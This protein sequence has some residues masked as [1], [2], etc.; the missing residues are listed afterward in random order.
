MPAWLTELH[1]RHN[2]VLKGGGGR[3][4]HDRPKS[5]IE[6]T[7]LFCIQTEN[8]FWSLQ[9]NGSNEAATSPPHRC[10]CHL[11]AAPGLFITERRA[12]Q[13]LADSSRGPQISPGG[14]GVCVL[15]HRE[16]T[17][18]HL[19]RKTRLSLWLNKSHLA[20]VAAIYITPENCGYPLCLRHSKQDFYAP[21]APQA[22][23]NDGK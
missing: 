22:W 14:R 3:R 13:A 6:V 4:G 8:C 10:C 2:R 23:L 12:W 15:C 1:T 21:S 11:S 20:S 17:I 19:C 16:H 7:F 18:D 9:R 5:E